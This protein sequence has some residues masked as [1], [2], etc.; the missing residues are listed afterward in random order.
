MPTSSAPTKPGPT[1]NA[2]DAGDVEA[3]RLERLGQQRVQGFDVGARGHLGH[4]AAESLVEVLLPRDQVGSQREAVLDDRDSR[5]VAGR[6]DAER[7]HS[8]P[9][10]GRMP[11]GKRWTIAATRRRNARSRMSSVHMI[12]ASSCSSA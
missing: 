11:S 9:T 1:V 4:H 5:L 10:C 7:D 3:G 2:V 6:F 8:M 12:S